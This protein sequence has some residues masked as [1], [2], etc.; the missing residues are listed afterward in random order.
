MKKKI[1]IL[2][3]IDDEGIKILKNFFFVK[4][5]Y[6]LSRS[7]QLKLIKS[8]NVIVIKSTTLIDRKFLDNCK[9]LELI[10]RA[11]TGLDNI[12]LNLIKE[13]KIKLVST[14]FESTAA[15]TEFTMMLIFISIKKFIKSQEMVKISDFRRAKVLGKDLFDLK[16]GIVGFGRIGKSLN[17][18]LKLFG[19][20]TLIY[21]PL[22]KDSI[23]FEYLLKNS[24]IISFH[25][26]LNQTNHNLITNKIINKMK[27]GI[28][29]INTSRAQ[30]FKKNFF[31]GVTKKFTLF[32]D[33]IH[34]E[35]SYNKKKNLIKHPWLNN[36]NIVFTPHMASM[37]ENTQR[38]IST[39]IS[40]LICKFYEK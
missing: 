39:K 6:N 27:N 38:K 31:L 9:K 37:T 23:S 29:L 8:S 19:A 4:T 12:D 13:K 14:P 18:K 1:L 7:K 21:D 16:V 10:A 11:G 32:T 3:K 20:K 30:I 33:V 26:T 24:D 2:E 28:I 35:P 25:V 34:P 5:G 36:K 15:V 40:N 17:K 22:Y